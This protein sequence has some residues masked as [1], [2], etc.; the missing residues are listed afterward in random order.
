MLQSKRTRASG[1]PEGSGSCRH[2]NGKTSCGETGMKTQEVCGRESASHSQE[3]PR[4]SPASPPAAGQEGV[5]L[6]S[7]LAGEGRV[8]VLGRA[9]GEDCVVTCQ[10]R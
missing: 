9:V 2:P 4:G 1:E 10:E 5:E 7:H 3:L 6:G 8:A